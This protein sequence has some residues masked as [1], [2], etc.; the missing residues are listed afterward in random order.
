[1]NHEDTERAL[2]SA[3]LVAARLSSDERVSV[4]V[5]S[6]VTQPNNRRYTYFVA[7]GRPTYWCGRCMERLPVWTADKVAALGNYGEVTPRSLQ[8]GCGEW[9]PV[10]WDTVEVDLGAP[11]TFSGLAVDL[12]AAVQ[13]AL[14]DAKQELR[15][16][17]AKRLERNL[18]D[19]VQHLDAS[20]GCPGHHDGDDECEMGYLVGDETN[21]GISLDGAWWLSWDYDPTSQDALDII[22][23]RTPATE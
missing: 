2:S 22:T 18:N 5:L 16:Q 7:A 19:W 23:L 1:M 17:V 3:R 14:E 9:A 6:A 21:P 12:V 20:P 11:E 8:H 15:D 10:V 13:E 4:A